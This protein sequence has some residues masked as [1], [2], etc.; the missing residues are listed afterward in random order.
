MNTWPTFFM[1]GSRHDIV[2]ISH[3]HRFIFIKTGKTAGT[4]VEIAL[5]K[6]CG[7]EDVITPISPEDEATRKT[8]ATGDR[9]TSKCH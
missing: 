1:P 5:S 4:S 6:F 2:I 3:R 8:S 7:P 9:R